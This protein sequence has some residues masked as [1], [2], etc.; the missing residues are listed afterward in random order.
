MINH[1]PEYRRNERC[2]NCLAPAV[3]L[4]TESMLL[5]WCEKG[6]ITNTGYDWDEKKQDEMRR[7]VGDNG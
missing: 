4:V 3:G 1:V 6:H 7:F 5:T 2:L